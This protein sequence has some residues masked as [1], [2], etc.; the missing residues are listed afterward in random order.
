MNTAI[1]ITTFDHESVPSIPCLFIV[2]TQAYIEVCDVEE[3][4]EYNEEL[5]KHPRAKEL[6][7]LAESLQFPYE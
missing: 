1:M 7:E 3:G 4:I 5:A 2:S 6:L